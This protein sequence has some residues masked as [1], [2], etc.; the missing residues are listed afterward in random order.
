MPPPDRSATLGITDKMSP[1]KTCGR[2]FNSDRLEMHQT[3]CQ[4]TAAKKRK[5]F[6]AMSHRIKV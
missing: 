2:N 5:T 1:C 6:D 3:I 4:K